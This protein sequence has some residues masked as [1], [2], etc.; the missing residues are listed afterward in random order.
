MKKRWIPIVSLSCALVMGLSMVGCGDPPENAN[1]AESYVSLNINPAIELTLNAEDKVLSV[2]GS[3][4][5]GQVLLYGET[6]EI[7]GVN[8]DQAV[9]KITELAKELGYFEDNTVINTT[10]QNDDAQKQEKLFNKINAKI[11]AKGTDLGLSLTVDKEQAFSL[12]RRYKAFLEENNL[13]EDQI[14]IEKFKLA[15][16]A[17]ET[18]EVSLEVAIEMDI[19]ELLEIVHNAHKNVKEYAT[20][21]FNKIKDQKQ[22]EL[23]QQIGEAVDSEYFNYFLHKGKLNSA[24]HAA[25]HKIYNSLARSLNAIADQIDY[26]EDLRYYTI[27]AETVT[28]ITTL[29]NITDVSVIQDSN[30]NVT[31]A[32]IEAYAD[33]ILKNMENEEVASQ[34]AD[35]LSLAIGQIEATVKQTADQ[36]IAEW[37]PKVSQTLTS[38]DTFLGGLNSGLTAYLGE[39]V[40]DVTD[41]TA[42]LQ[43]LISDGLDSDALREYAKEMEEKAQEM[44]AK[45]KL[46]IKNAG[47]DLSNKINQCKKQFD[48]A[49]QAVDNHLA[50]REA[51]FRDH[52]NGLKNEYRGDPQPQN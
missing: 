39:I 47:D 23:E 18:G 12:V 15:F 24:Y 35:Q 21:E 28:Q 16:S 6:D 9:A 19:D 13:T 40:T 36:L 42:K 34:L 46:A 50:E 4:E 48:D 22:A 26:I 38:I 37:A 7:I 33:K 8:I 31:I 43:T 20:R 51:H 1:T 2:Y 41:M 17:S 29:L 5:D 32:S 25:G 30:G 52:L 49:K 11:T 3:N 27:P 14:S 10:V 44:F 45:M